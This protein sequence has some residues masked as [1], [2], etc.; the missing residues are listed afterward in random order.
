MFRVV[1]AMITDCSAGASPGVSDESSVVASLK[2]G[3]VPSMQS[4]A[5]QPASRARRPA[6]PP[7]GLTPVPSP[8]TEVRRGT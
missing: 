5:K 2:P 8:I 4:V 6:N 1:V 3:G 7:P